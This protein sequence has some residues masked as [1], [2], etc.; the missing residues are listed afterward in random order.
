M[1]TF[2]E[3]IVCPSF[4]GIAIIICASESFKQNLASSEGA[5][6]NEED[7]QKTTLASARQAKLHELRLPIKSSSMLKDLFHFPVFV[8]YKRSPEVEE[9]TWNYYDDDTGKA[10]EDDYPDFGDMEKRSEDALGSHVRVMRSDEG[11]H[12]RIM[13]ASPETHVRVMRASPESHVR[14]MRAS[15]HS[16]VRVMRAP[17]KSHVRVMRESPGSHVRVMR[18]SPGSHAR[19][20]RSTVIGTPQIRVTRDDSGY[21]PQIRII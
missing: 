15:P 11:S 5:S 9:Q 1:N 7:L 17:Q 3:L 20:M 4:I 12:V 19:V 18:A 21:K 16:H 6:N 13:R 2:L 14:V 8:S 10:D